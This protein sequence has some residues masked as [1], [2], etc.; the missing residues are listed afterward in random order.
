MRKTITMPKLK[1]CPFC[2]GEA[3]LFAESGIR[4]LCTNCHAQTRVLHDG[5]TA[6]GRIMGNATKSVIEAWN[7]RI[8]DG[9]EAFLD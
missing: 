8:D 3:A 5:L 1:Y 7:K 6:S 9:P 2:G 4:V